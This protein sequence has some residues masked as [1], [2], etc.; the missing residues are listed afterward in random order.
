[1]EINLEEMWKK[2]LSL[3]IDEICKLIDVWNC[4]T[5][6]EPTSLKL[7][8][9]GAVQR[10]REDGGKKGVVPVCAGG[11]IGGRRWDRRLAA[12]EEDIE[13]I[14]IVYV[15]HN[16]KAFQGRIEKVTSDT[17]AINESP[18]VVAEV[19]YDPT[20]PRYIKDK[21]SRIRHLVQ[22]RFTLIHELAIERSQS[23]VVVGTVDVLPAVVDDFGEDVSGDWKRS[24][25]AIVSCHMFDH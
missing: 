11:G 3:F 24:F 20:Q 25:G 22:S 16:S 6:S 8:E 12:T 1:M 7:H 17:P 14:E 4:E 13:G 5:K 23:F 9:I 18:A 19:S 21:P 15:C 2:Y 10:K